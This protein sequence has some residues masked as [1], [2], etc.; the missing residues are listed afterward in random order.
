[1]GLHQ[2]FILNVDVD[3]LIRDLPREA[4]QGGSN[5]GFLEAV[6]IL[7]LRLNFVNRHCKILTLQ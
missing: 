5:V 7:S 2:Q 4:T 6:G 3:D 1:M